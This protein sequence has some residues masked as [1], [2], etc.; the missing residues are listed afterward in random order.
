MHNLVR[1]GIE[2]LVKIIPNKSCFKK[3]KFTDFK[4]KQKIANKQEINK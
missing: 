1:S 4:E 3:N 2:D